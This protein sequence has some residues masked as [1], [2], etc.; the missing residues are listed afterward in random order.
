M[1]PRENITLFF[2]D[3]VHCHWV[4][5]AYYLQ[6][7]WQLHLQVSIISLGVHCPCFKDHAVVSPTKVNGPLKN[8]PLH[9]RNS[10]Q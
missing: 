7:V 10:R 2:W 9:I 3:I 6:T 8:T 1:K 4:S 5:V